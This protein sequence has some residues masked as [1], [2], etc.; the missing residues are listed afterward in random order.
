[1]YEYHRSVVPMEARRGHKIPGVADGCEPPRACWKLNPSPL[2]G[3]YV[4][5]TGA[6]LQQHYA[7]ISYEDISYWL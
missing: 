5:L 1:M 7:L 2:Q 6:S 3:Q 4:P